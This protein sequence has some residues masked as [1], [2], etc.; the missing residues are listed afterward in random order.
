[1]NGQSWDLL[2]VGAGPAGL[3]GAVAARRLGLS[4]LVVD[5]QTDPGG[6]FYRHAGVPAGLREGLLGPDAR[7][8]E[9][10]VRAFSASGASFRPETLVWQL[11]RASGGGWRVQLAE[12][13]GRER[14]WSAQAG[15]VLLATGAQ[16]RPFPVPGWT[17]PGVM[18]LG[19]AQ[20][21]LKTTGLVP[22]PETVL[23]GGG[24]LLYLFAYQLLLAG[25]RVQALVETAPPGAL[26]S[27]FPFLPAALGGA[28][29]LLKGVRMLAALRRARIPRH[30]CASRIQVLGGGAAEAVQFQAGGGQRTLDTPLVLLHQ[31]LVPGTSLGRT[32]GCDLLWDPL[33]ACWRP[34]VDAWGRSSV[35]G[36]WIAG[37]GAA[38]GG[39][40][41]ARQAGTLAALD[42]A[43]E[44]GRLDPVRR[45]ALARPERRGARGPRAVG[46]FLD[47][48][49]LPPPELRRPADPVVVCRCEEVTAGEIRT[50]AGQGCAGPNQLK[51]F[52]RC[53]MGPCQGRF[54]GTAVTELMAEAQGRDPAD[55]G[56]FRIRPPVKPI[57]LAALAAAAAPAER[58]DFPS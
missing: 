13:P 9:A 31:G 19:G 53:G 21:M 40:R 14:A 17:L 32:L 24:P 34:R 11:G 6:H 15:A 7:E 4:V 12:G 5:E 22:A 49:Y 56:H 33:R 38:V 3:A 42:I 35:A 57:P 41:L 18:G 43:A 51:A 52:S 55:V 1:M 44:A 50:L 10:L 58:G 48:F 36:V 37:D 28:G 39:A 29:Q 25:R 46:E 16:E 20:L 8:G 23:V 2:V 47:H 30:R 26:G 27:A 45:E 54:C